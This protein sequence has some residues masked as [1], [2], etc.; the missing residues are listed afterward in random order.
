MNVLSWSYNPVEDERVHV[1]W[2]S[3]LHYLLLSGVDVLFLLINDSLGVVER[4][5]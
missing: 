3:T 4:L 2:L 5:V 1:P